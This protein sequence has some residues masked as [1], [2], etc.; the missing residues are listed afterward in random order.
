MAASAR[1]MSTDSDRNPRPAPLTVAREA[2]SEAVSQPPDRE[3][4][5]PHDLLAADL[6][7]RLRHTALS[8][9]AAVVVIAG[10]TLGVWLV[11]P[12]AIPWFI[13]MKL[14]T[15]FGLCCV[16]LC[17]LL[18]AREERTAW[19]RRGLATAAI[20]IGVATLLQ[21]ALGAN[22]GIDELLVSDQ[23]SVGVPGRMGSNTAL[24]LALLGLAQLTMPSRPLRA[25]VLAVAAASLSLL[26]VIGYAFAVPTLYA[27]G[28]HTQMA[29]PTALCF[30][31]LSISTLL[32][33]PDRGLVSIFTA[34]ASG[35][36]MARRLIPLI[37]IVP[38]FTGWL[39]MRAVRSGVYDA[40]FAAS[41]EA[42]VAISVFAAVVLLS[43]RTMNSLDRQQRA[44]DAR[45]RELNALLE[46][47]AQQLEE[48]VRELESFSYSVSHDL[49]SPIR[50]ISGFAE[51][52]EKR[53]AGAVDAQARHY[54]TTISTS[55][56]RAGQLIDDLL[57]FSRM[58]RAPVQRAKVPLDRM[59][60]EVWQELATERAGRAIDFTMGPLPTVSA[61]PQLLRLVIQ[62]LLSNAI[63]Y[64]A[65][66][67]Q[68]RIELS[69][70]LGPAETIVSVKDNGA[71][72]DMA[73]ADKLFGVF[74]RLHG[75]PFEGVGIG[76][77]NVKRI[78]Q[79]HG[80][81]VW[82]YAEVDRGATFFFALPNQSAG[83]S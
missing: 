13:M 38:L 72:F 65:Q 17:G 77:A 20:S 78:V 8:L 27:I 68:P 3:L 53:A 18:L 11:T 63:K 36:F 62:N 15:A 21:Y 50:H 66:R 51:L 55:A 83:E 26:A 45:I 70:S 74:Q 80:G 30:L 82:A 25:Q 6:G 37:F 4:T 46:K 35:G 69:A 59:V 67:E 47:R 61:D 10:I 19:L 2:P 43:A 22:F 33:R 14:N 44:A 16:S 81:R 42:L 58:A 39:S 9:S 54:L 5:S 71:G 52:L 7:R 32:W 79:R 48:S 34:P 56:R 49:R 1:R 40:A 23:T 60:D 41:I 73:Y 64:T 24:V 12:S 76:L 75:A 31:S 29:L 57:A 28:H